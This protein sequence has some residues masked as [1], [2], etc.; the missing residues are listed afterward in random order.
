MY[1]PPRTKVD[2]KID[3]DRVATER[4]KQELIDEIA[5]GRP[6]GRLG[7]GGGSTNGT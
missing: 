5:D 6:G 7:E 3:S 4:V 1:G 2:E